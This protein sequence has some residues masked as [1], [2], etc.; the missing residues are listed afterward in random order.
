M[1]YRRLVKTS[2]LED[3]S[4]RRYR[5]LL[6]LACGLPIAVI[7]M[8]ATIVGFITYVV[9]HFVQKYW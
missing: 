9:V 7:L 1:T 8:W 4:Y 6:D 3:F 2:E 5:F